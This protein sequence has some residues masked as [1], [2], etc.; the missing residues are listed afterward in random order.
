MSDNPN[1]ITTGP[2]TKGT[3]AERPS[4]SQQSH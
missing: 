2:S 3:V 4:L 1:E